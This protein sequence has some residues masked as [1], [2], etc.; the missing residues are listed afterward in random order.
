MNP[1]Y[2]NYEGEEPWFS[3]E[4]RRFRIMSPLYPTVG[5]VE[6]ISDYMVMA[7]HAVYSDDGKDPD[8]GRHYSEILDPDSWEDMFC[9]EEY[10][11]EWDGE[12][13]SFY[14]IK[15]RDDPCLYCGPMWD[16][17]HEL[18]GDGGLHAYVPR[19]P[20]RLAA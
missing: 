1:Q 13:W 15:D 7:E 20:P 9:L 18:S 2:S 17:D 6:Y 8:T 11:V 5:Q 3:T 10:F 12:R 4:Y 19:Q 14:I 16:F